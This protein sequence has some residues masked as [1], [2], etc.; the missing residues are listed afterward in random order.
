MEEFN[1]VCHHIASF[2]HNPFRIF[3]GHKMHKSQCRANNFEVFLSTLIQHQIITTRNANLM[4]YFINALDLLEKN[5]GMRQL[6]S[7]HKSKNS[8]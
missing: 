7:D 1:K 5:N 2:F 3:V 6:L 8:F 4:S